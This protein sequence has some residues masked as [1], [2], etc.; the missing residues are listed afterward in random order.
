[1]GQDVLVKAPAIHRLLSHPVVL[2]ASKALL[3]RSSRTVALKLLSQGAR[4]WTGLPIMLCPTELPGDK[5]G[6]GHLPLIEAIGPGE[7]RFPDS[8]LLEEQLIAFLRA[9]S[10]THNVAVSRVNDLYERAETFSVVRTA[11]SGYEWPEYRGPL[12]AAA[13]EGA[14]ATGSCF[15]SRTFCSPAKC[16]FTFTMTLDIIKA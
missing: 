8:D 12:G 11:S 1:M 15:P 4:A 16:S 14:E 13:D 9:S 3:C 6:F 7:V 2:A 5:V 10:P